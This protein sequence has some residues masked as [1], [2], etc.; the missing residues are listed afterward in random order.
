M[1]LDNSLESNYQKFVKDKE[2]LLNTIDIAE[3]I[4]SIREVTKLI[5]QFK[6]DKLKSPQH[7]ADSN[8]W[9]YA[10][11]KRLI[12]RIQPYK[13]DD[14]EFENNKEQKSDSDALNEDKKGDEDALK[15]KRKWFQNPSKKFDMIQKTSFIRDSKNK[16]NV[17]SKLE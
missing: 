6:N 5:E 7:D 4:T 15:N 10:D 11:T 13:E 3:I 2:R 17:I 9:H 12:K 14:F 8:R 1:S 16:V